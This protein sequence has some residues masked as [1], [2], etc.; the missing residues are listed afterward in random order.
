LEASGSQIP[1]PYPR[2]GTLEPAHL[3]SPLPLRGCHPLRR[4]FPGRF[5]SRG[6]G[7]RLAQNPTY[8]HGFPRGFGL[9]WSPFTRRY[10]GS[11][12]LISFPRPT[13]MLPFGRFPLHRSRQWSDTQ[14]RSAGCQEIP[15][16]HPRINAC[17]RLPGAYRSLPRPSSA[18][19]PSY[20]PAGVLWPRASG[21]S[22]LRRIQHSGRGHQGC[23]PL[24]P[25]APTRGWMPS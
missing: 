17:L 21:S 4:T 2:C 5:G 13:W 24:P 22:T 7:G 11:L 10:S 3:H 23:K 9:A 8:P 16:G 20:P 18:P 1:T 19:K 25:P 14:R 12:V 15:F 6:T